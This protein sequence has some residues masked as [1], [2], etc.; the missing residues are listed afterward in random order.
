MF[1]RPKDDSHEFKPGLAE[2]EDEPLNPLGRTIFWIIVIGIVFLGGWMYWGRV[3][4]VVSARGKVIPAGEIK[5]LQPL[6]SGVVSSIL[7]KEGD[8][9]EKGQVLMEIDPSTTEPE[10]DSKRKDAKQLELELL[11][12]QA[13]LERRP[14]KPPA[15]REAADLLAV[16]QRLYASTLVRQQQQIQAKEEELQQADEQL[17]GAKAACQRLRGLLAMA[18][19]RLASLE[20]VRDIISQDQYRQA[21]GEVKSASGTLIEAEHRSRELSATVKRI[22]SEI[23]V[24]EETERDRALTELSDKRTKLNYLRGDIEKTTY[25]NARQQLVAPVGGF[26]NKLLI[27][28][29]GGVVTPAEKLI[30][31][32]PADSPLVISTLVQNKDIGFI[33]REMGASIK[34]DTFNFQKYGTLNGRVSHV[35]KDSIEDKEL[36]LVYEVYVEPRETA[37]LVEGVSTPIT[38]GMSVVAEIKV[39]KRRIIEFFIYPLIKYLDEGISVR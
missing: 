7:V 19:E 18:E 20:P 6:T 36:G 2:I 9:V 12:L 32:V 27:H 34:V 16:Q 22:R 10:L 33:A 28:T 15:E 24:I 8:L 23:T 21:E 30:A 39:G 37:L 25:I 13:V 3:D 38:T 31:L 5:I 17:A 29:V 11:R 14:F 26:I 35:A 1:L 4:V